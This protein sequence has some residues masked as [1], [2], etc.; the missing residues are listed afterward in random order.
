[1]LV[2]GADIGTE[3]VKAIVADGQ[4]KV[5]GRAAVP[6]R[7]YFHDCYQE[8]M[9]VALAEAQAREAALDAVCVTG[10]G[11]SCVPAATQA[12]TDSLCHARGAFHHLPQAM[13]LVDIGGRDPKLVRVDASGAVLSTR[14]VRKCAVGIGTFLMFAARH[15]DVHPTRLQDLAS[16]AGSAARV[17][18]YCSVLAEVDVIEMLRAGA[19]A[20][21]IALGCMASIAERILEMDRLEG[22]VRVSGG[23]CEYFPGVVKALSERS[24]LPAEIVPEP[25]MVGALG[26]ALY[27]LDAARGRKE[28]ADGQSAA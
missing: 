10:F 6:T 27:A 11:A 4:G 19:S 7:G 15:L 14:S 9:G 5:L 2:A 13:T 17:G 16:T 18:S 24:G 1:M 25:I 20:G 21:E 26:A 28:R 3:C 8:A 22:P 23:V 12:V